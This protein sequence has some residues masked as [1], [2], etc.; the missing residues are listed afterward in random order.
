MKKRW[1]NFGKLLKEGKDTEGFAIKGE[2]WERERKDVKK[3]KKRWE[4][5]NEGER[6]IPSESSNSKEEAASRAD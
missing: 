6:R 3:K 1:R 4:K 2:I 5:Y